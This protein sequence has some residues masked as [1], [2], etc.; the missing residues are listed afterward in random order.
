MAREE[1]QWRE[2]NA[3]AYAASALPL[4]PPQRL[5]VLCPP[6]SGSELLVD[7]LD[8]LPGMRCS[9]EVLHQRKVRW[10]QRF[11]EGRARLA[12]LGGARAYGCKVLT[13]HLLPEE[14]RLGPAKPIVQDLVDGGWTVVQLRRRDLLATALSH[15]Q[16]QET[17]RW[18]ERG[19]GPPEALP[20]IEADAGTV[21]AWLHSAA[22][23]Q[24]WLD[25]LL[26]DLPHHTVTYE[27]DLLHER[28]R[29]AAID[30]IAGLV[31]LE[32]APVAARL[33]KGAPVDPWQRLKDPEP[34][35]RLLRETAF[36]HLVDGD[37]TSG[38]GGSG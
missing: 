35:R 34:L 22:S 26:A 31:G 8:Q 14:D 11:L 12:R 37:G 36:A 23:Y 27:D 24:Q 25:D 4:R 18:H 13:H 29:Q 20:L 19:S 7:L 32:P 2:S 6:R 33:Q 17:G 38:E 5:V 21:F 15:L 10:P 9:G 16:A 30:T 1:T 3:A 28:D